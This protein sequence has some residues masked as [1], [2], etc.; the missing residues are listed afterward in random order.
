M[1]K[2]IIMIEKVRERM[3]KNERVRKKSW[4]VRKNKIEKELQIVIKKEKD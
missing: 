4:K 1:R 2:S 3:R